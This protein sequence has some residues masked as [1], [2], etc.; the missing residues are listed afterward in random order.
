MVDFAA[1]QKT[2]AAE[3]LLIRVADARL[4][5]YA[6]W[7][8]QYELVDM[9]VLKALCEKLTSNGAAN[10]EIAKRFAQLYSFVIQKYIKGQ[11]L[12]VVK[13]MSSNYL[14]SV[15]AEVENKC[16]GKLLGTPQATLTLAVQQSNLDALRAEHDKLLG[17]GNQA[18][19]LAA[20][21]NF[22][23]GSADNGRN[24]PQVLPDP[25]RQQ[26]VAETP[27]NP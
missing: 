7:T 15:I 17:A 22:T 13:E 5:G 24:E 26:A 21:L 8:V 1:R 27:S 25:P 9:A 3:E 20:K 23:Y 18:G 10:P 16:L 4:A 19:L 2:A 6:D 11:E 12:G 14:A